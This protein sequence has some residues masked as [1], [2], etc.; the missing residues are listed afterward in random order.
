MKNTIQLRKELV[1]S[2]YQYLRLCDSESTE[3][4][5]KHFTLEKSKDADQG[6]CVDNVFV[7]LES[8]EAEK[9]LDRFLNPTV[10]HPNPMDV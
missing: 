9:N 3:P 8:D 5:I 1:Q 10:I 4:E 2:G 6:F 7:D